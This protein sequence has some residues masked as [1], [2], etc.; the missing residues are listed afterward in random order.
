MSRLDEIIFRHRNRAY[1]AYKL[2]RRSP[3]IQSLAAFAAMAAFASFFI[4]VYLYYHMPDDFGGT[5]WYYY[6]NSS[7]SNPFQADLELIAEQKGGEEKKESSS[8]QITSE[9]ETQDSV[10]AEKDMHGQDSMAGGNGATGDIT[11]GDT[12]YYGDLNID[13]TGM[14]EFEM[15]T[16]IDKPPMFPGGEKARLAYLQKNIVYPEFAWKNKVEGPVYVTFIVEKDSTITN[17]Q[18]LQGIGAG[19][20]DE[21]MRVVRE[22]PRW[23]PGLKNGA[24]HRFQITMPLI[25]TIH[26]Q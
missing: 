4:A 15:T 24:M 14:Q 25:F 10:V 21:A 5:E 2:R 23:A 11:E 13:K 6:D 9:P 16:R 19:C 18:I 3:H 17:I 7:M 20:D 22:M 12:L 1:G 8:M 26:T